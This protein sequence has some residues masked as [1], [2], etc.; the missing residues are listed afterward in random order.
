MLGGA[1]EPGVRA[2]E[3]LDGDLE[4]RPG[5]PESGK[6]AL[7]GLGE[8]G[9]G[10]APGGGQPRSRRAVGAGARRSRLDRS[11][12]GLRLLVEFCERRSVPAGEFHQLVGFTAVAALEPPQQ[13][14]P[15]LDLG[16]PFRPRPDFGATGPD[17]VRQIFD[18]GGEVGRPSRRAAIVGSI[19]AP[20]SSARAATAICAPAESS[21]P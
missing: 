14:Q 3:R 15:I 17:L 19:E 9:G 20:R 8:R 16:Q 6:F 21:A 11:P 1:L 5:N 2:V 7:D 13:R 18:L 4:P 12:A 10:V